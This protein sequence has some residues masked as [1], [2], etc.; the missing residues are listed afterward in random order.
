MGS[1]ILAQSFLLLLLVYP[2]CAYSKVYY[3]TPSLDNPC[4]Q[5]TSSC[6]TLSWFAANS[7]HNE[8]DI[9][10][11]ILKGNHTLDQ[12]LFLANRHNISMSKYA[13]DN[14]T[15][16]VECTSQLGRFYISQTISVSIMDLHFNGC[17]SN[18]VS[19]V[20][21]LT[22]ADSIFQDVENNRTVL[23]LNDVAIANID[24]S[25]FLN[26]TCDYHKV[27]ISDSFHFEKLLKKIS[28]NRPTGVLYTTFSN[29]SIINSAFMYNRADFGG[30]LV[31]HNI[32][33]HIDRSTYSCNKAIFGG[34][35]VTLSSTI[36]IDS[37]NFSANSAQQSGGVMVT[38]NDRFSIWNS[39]FRK[40]NANK[41]AGVMI[42]FGKSSITINSSTFTSNSAS[43]YSVLMALDYS[44]YTISNSYF[45]NSYA[46]DAGV[47]MTANDSSLNI[48]DSIFTLNTARN[49]CSI[50]IILDKSQSTISNCT[51]YNNSNIRGLV[52]K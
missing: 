27:K 5:N 2:D 7:S 31:T 25:H 9:S 32:S 14:E 33:L 22:I 37:C 19:Q 40:N 26:N 11:F 21:W 46:V 45:T 48:T 13:E 51:F 34:A 50:V 29:I 1:Q 49:C 20:T 38:Y 41:D 16:F 10:L 52:L 4:P 30:A 12:E 15:V 18:R 39:T 8:T 44:S 24:R 42:T 35:M 28:I 17:G 3:I 6:L 43:V 23:E 36:A 47:I